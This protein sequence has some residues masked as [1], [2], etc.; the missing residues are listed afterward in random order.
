MLSRKSDLRFKDLPCDAVVMPSSN[1]K[2]H[3]SFSQLS[4]DL[5][6][7][8]GIYKEKKMYD[9]CIFLFIMHAL[10]DNTDFIKSL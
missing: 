5:L 3:I 10:K 6:W 1:P 2:A 4:I 7:N 9:L 8:S